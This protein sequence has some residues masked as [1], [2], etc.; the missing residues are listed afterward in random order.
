MIVTTMASTQRTMAW[1]SSRL[2]KDSIS[3]EF[4]IVLACNEVDDEVSRK[5][6]D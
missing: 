6:K 5:F 1:L 3:L 2:D 4:S